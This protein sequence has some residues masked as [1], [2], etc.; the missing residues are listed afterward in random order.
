M[1]GNTTLTDG[2]GCDTLVGGSGAHLFVL[3]RAAAAHS[4]VIQGFNPGT[5]GLIFSGFGS[6]A[7]IAS[8]AMVGGNLHLVLADSA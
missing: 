3:T 4:E 1:R 5:D 8:Q 6:A 2:S 7:P